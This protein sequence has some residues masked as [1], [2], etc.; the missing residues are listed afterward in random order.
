MPWSLPEWSQ[1]PVA[2]LAAHPAC[3]ILAGSD[4]VVAGVRLN[5]V[6]YGHDTGRPPV[7]FVH[8]V[9]G[10][11]Q[12]WDGVLRDLRHELRMVA[13][14]LAGLGRS[15]HPRGRVDLAAQANLLVALLDDLGVADR[16]V[17]VGH[18]LGGA[19]SV[20]LAGL[21]PDRVA[22]LV[23]I[24]SPVHADVWPPDDLVPLLVPGLRSG[25]ARRRRRRNGLDQGL[26]EILRSVDMPTVEAVWEMLRCAPPPALVLW[27]ED[28]TRFSTAYGRRLAG[29]LSGSAWVPV[30]G[31]GHLLPWE[32]PERVAEEI[33]GFVA[34]LPGVR[35][36]RR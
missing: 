15:E 10:D 8:G 22:G 18:D 23:L 33:S 1:A 24:S 9:P 29:D 36:S 25:L 34:D 17:L 19:V 14:D 13:V 7:L 6:T 31:A 5:V 26:V 11:A 20:L 27:G 30:S 28:D 4:H 2:P 35:R 12:M 3:P 16:C 32:R 21:V